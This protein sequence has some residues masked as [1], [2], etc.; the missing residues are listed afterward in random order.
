MRRRLTRVKS[1]NPAA[2]ILG[3]DI[4]RKFTGLAIC[5]NEFKVAR[6]F[7]TLTVDIS[8]NKA[9]NYK[10]SSGMLRALRNTIRNHNIKGLVVGYPLLQTEEDDLK[11]ATTTRHCLFVE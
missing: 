9:D 10:E 1:L 5:D 6:G 8:N 7:K 11:V 4:G 3:L 2:R